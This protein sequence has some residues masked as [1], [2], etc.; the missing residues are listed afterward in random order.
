V[1]DLKAKQWTEMS[2]SEGELYFVP[3]QTSVTL[4]HFS[5]ER[6]F[7]LNLQCCYLEFWDA[8]FHPIRLGPTT[9]C[10][11]GATIYYGSGHT[12][13]LRDPGYGS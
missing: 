13:I 6:T 10:F 8:T 12:L 2:D 11:H 1:L 4:L 7:D 9:S 3:G 5:E